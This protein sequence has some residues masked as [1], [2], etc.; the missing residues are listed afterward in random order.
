[1]RPWP[2]LG[3]S[4]TGKKEKNSSSNT[5]KENELHKRYNFRITIRYCLNVECNMF[6]LYEKDKSSLGTSW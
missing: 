2:A 4:A 1:M 6:D 5:A 3:R